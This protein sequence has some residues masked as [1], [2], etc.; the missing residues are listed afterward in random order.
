[1]ILVGFLSLMLSKLKYILFYVNSF[2]G[3]SL[4]HYTQIGLDRLYLLY[5][6]INELFV[7]FESHFCR[8]VVDWF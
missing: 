1:M 5:V 6:L 4:V 7:D 8:V 2:V 3:L